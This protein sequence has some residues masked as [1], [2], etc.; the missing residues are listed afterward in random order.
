MDVDEDTPISADAD[1]KKSNKGKGKA[2]ET[3]KLESKI[4]EEVIIEADLEELI[5][6]LDSVDCCEE[7]ARCILGW[8]GS[9]SGKNNWYIRIS[10][11]V[12][13]IGIGLL[14]QGGVSLSL[15]SLFR[16]SAHF[17]STQYGSQPLEAFQQQWRQHS[18]KF[19][20]LCQPSL[21]SV[22]FHF[23]C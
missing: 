2:V 7:V 21:L 15:Q 9:E 12:K 16:A 5:S 4:A 8:F 13:E 6:T 10:E 14:A 22:S 23:I 11:V 3:K 17:L 1:K 19:K 20:S 18:S